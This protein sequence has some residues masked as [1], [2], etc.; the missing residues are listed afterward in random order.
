MFALPESRPDRAL[1]RADLSVVGG[2]AIFTLIVR[3]VWFGD[4]NADIDEQLYSLIGN[5][6]LDGRIPYVDLWDRKPW[7]LFAIF[8][9]AHAVGGPGPLAYQVLAAI[10][11]LAGAV[12]TFM[13][14]RE[15]AERAVAAAA[16]ALYV[17]FTALYGA[18]SANSEVFFI[19]L[20]LAMAMLVR[21]P[22]H[23][24]AV[25]RALAAMLIGGIALQIKYTVLP[26]C[27]FFGG[28]VLWSQHR[29]GMG[30]SRLAAMACL[31]ALLGLMP[32]VLIAAGYML[33]GHGEA[34]VFANFVSFFDR[35]PA[36][37]GRFHSQILLLLM[38]LVGLALLGL[39]AARRR[40]ARER[41]AYGFL[42]MWLAAA[43]ATVFLPS[44]VYGYYL[45]ALVPPCI[46]LALPLFAQ[47][48]ESRSSI[49]MLLPA[50]L[51]LGLLPFNY[52]VSQDSRAATARMA[53]AIAPLVD[54]Q[55]RCL[56][57]FDGP[58]ALYRLSESCLPTRFIY[59]DHLNN[60]LE[61][62]ALGIRQE[63]EVARILAARPPVIVTADTPLTPQ[64]AEA[65]ARVRAAVARDYRP[66]A[67]ELFH[68]RRIRAWAL[69]E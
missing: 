39:N 26:Q 16:A 47:G 22:E 62:N 65:L 24:H 60:V 37:A 9:L 12:L 17:V 46:L 30:L 10:A 36:S 35:L 1:G 14:A 64:N 20:T 11:T 66:L 29:R 27:L 15:L 57:V 7:G 18:H 45:A 33:A 41:R 44:T 38:P 2:L 59:P 52:G 42:A 63:D 69:R 6:M 34:F 58:T 67:Q 8:A 32:T 50:V 3:S 4:A 40:P 55:S 68:K 61:R 31:C 23:R 19:P 48:K 53:G 5:A 49:L 25:P 21:A 56:F 54:G 43:L 13:L 51:Y 28:W